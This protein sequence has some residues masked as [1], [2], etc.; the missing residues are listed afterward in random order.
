MLP[1]FLQ[2]A[3]VGY[4]IIEIKEWLEKKR[5][6][7]WLDKKE[8]KEFKCFR[9]GNE[10]GAK[11]GKYF[12]RLEGMPI[13]GFRFYIHLCREKG[14]CEK[15]KKARAEDIEFISKET[16]HLTQDYAWWLGRICEIASV[17]RV[18]EL[19][20]LNSMSMWRLDLARMRRMLKHYKIPEVTKITVD[21]VYARKKAKHANESRNDRF[22]TVI[23]DL[24]TRKVIW[25]SDSRSKSGLDEFF[26]IIG[27]EACKKIEVV[28]MDQHED[29]RASAREYCPQATV[30]W[31]RFHIMQNFEEAVNETRKTLHEEL[32]KKSDAARL[33][34]G[35][36]RFLFL[37]KA[38]RRTEDER[39]HLNEVFKE[40]ELFAKL[41]MIKERMITFFDEQTEEGAKKVFEEVGDWI[42]QARFEPLMKW[43][44]NLEKQWV[45]LKNYFTYRVTTAL[46][47]GINNV[48]KMLKRR[49]FGYRNMQ[50]F[51]LKIMQVCGYLNSRFIP[52]SLAL[53]NQ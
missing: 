23:S 10:L 26:K 36:Y 32:L 22:F 44:T 35:K 53:E 9:C 29:Y 18:A 12:L 1:R 14:V 25:V 51:K 52:N 24:V 45:T 30:V 19:H 38:A 39:A 46:S 8:E 42:W 6:D 17:S 20:E 31:D 11:R 41:E 5:I 3:F 33:T 28:A 13:M 27:E 50:Y 43:Y 37:K 48:I 34:R 16:P 15:C 4:E 7:I 40:N 21:E 2:K 49:A 47:E